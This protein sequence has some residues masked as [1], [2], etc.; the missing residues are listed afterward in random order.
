MHKKILRIASLLLVL[1]VFTGMIP[2]TETSAAG[3]EAERICALAESTYRQAL[4]KNNRKSFH[5]WCGAAVDWQMRLL[6]ITTK[7][8]GSNGNDKFDQY[9]YEK[10]TSGGYQI[11]ALPKK[12]YKL[13]E[14]LNALTDNGTKNAYNIMVGFQRTNTSAGRK[15]GHATFIYAIIDGM[16][17]FTESYTMHIGGKRYAEGKCIAVTIE[18]FA[19]HYNSWCTY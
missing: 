7:V 19:K 18:Q 17:Y 12:Q 10:Y 6:G 9:R 14:A 2:A 5:G 4:K 16:V 15:Y 8:V 3:S 11:T 1:L 13:E